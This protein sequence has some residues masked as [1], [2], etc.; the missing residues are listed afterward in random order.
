MKGKEMIALLA[1]GS[2]ALSFRARAGLNMQMTAT[3]PAAFVHLELHTPDLPAACDF[4]A[5]LCGW[6]E[7]RVRTSAGTYLALDLGASADARERVGG[8]VVQCA[9][10][11]PLWLPYVQVLDIDE[12]IAHA[13]L[14]GAQ[15]LLEPREG[16]LGWR[17]VVATRAAGV[18]AFWQPK[19]PVPGSVAPDR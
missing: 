5:S 10:E 12:A 13:R 3:D 7:E 11:R 4:Y 18:L 16:P 19:R 1:P 6:R 17:A 2:P 15:V 9:V 8:G 14:L